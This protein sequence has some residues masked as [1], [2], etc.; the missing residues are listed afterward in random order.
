[1]DGT[2]TAAGA[3]QQRFL[4]GETSNRKETPE[5]RA[6]KEAKRRCSCR[7][8]YADRGI[9]FL[10]KSFADF[11]KA[12]GR[13]PSKSHVLDRIDNDGHYELG[14]VRWATKSESSKNRRMTPQW[15]RHLHKIRRL[16]R[17]TP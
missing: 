13:K 1:M 4:H 6:Y 2:F 11:L 8:Y 12:I 10:F 17:S 3:K 9:K 15:L 5:F 14:N 7:H 16:Q